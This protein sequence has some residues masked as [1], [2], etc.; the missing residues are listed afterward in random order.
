M[1]FAPDALARLL[2]EAHRFDDIIDV[3][4]PSEFAEDHIPGAINLPVLSDDE[5]ARV[6][7]I[8]TRESPFLARKIGAALVARNAA[9]HLEDVLADRPGGWQPLLYCWRGGQRSN[10]FA[11]ILRQIG[12][13]VEV[14]EGGYKHYRKLVMAALAAPP[15]CPVIVL[16][17]NTGTAKTALLPHLAR[18]GVQAIDLEGLAGHRGSVFGAIDRQPS[19]KLF[20]SRLAFAL[21]GLS[22]TSVLLLEAESHRIGALR[23]PAGIWRAMQAAPRIELSAPLAARAGHLTSAYGD[24]AAD[25]VRLA[26]TIDRL[27][28]L[29]AAERIAQWQDLAARG[30]HAELAKS[31]ML[32]HYDPAYARVRVRAA[33]RAPAG[34]QA[35]VIANP[36][37]PPPVLRLQADDLRPE[38]LPKLA[39]R[40]AAAARAMAT[41]AGGM[42]GGETAGGGTAGGVA[43]A[44]LKP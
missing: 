10:S 8:Y 16:D 29:H 5:R 33:A 42:A 44:P 19:Q 41:G 4:A 26:A 32:H 35:D 23:L 34:P 6:G 40:I 43:P 14:I 2:P 3:R 17:G 13:R 37:T 24:I 18:H 25:P 7:T 30:A 28:P 11:V 15:P 36:Q 20:E 39:E 27:R 22:A 21:A 12:W 31:L 1:P 9:R 38:A